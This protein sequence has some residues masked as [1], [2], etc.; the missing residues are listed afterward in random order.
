[1]TERSLDVCLYGARVPVSMPRDAPSADISADCIQRAYLYL[2]RDV[3]AGE[4]PYG[5]DQRQLMAFDPN[6]VTGLVGL[7]PSQAWR[8]GDPSSHPSGPRRFS[9]WRYELPEVR[10]YFTEEVVTQLLDAIEP[11]AVGM[12]IRLGLS[13]DH[14]QYVFLPD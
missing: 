2:Q 9:S 1:M 8:R 10:T 11:H 3:D 14:D 5:A 12:P 4:P 13:V 6:D 7:Q